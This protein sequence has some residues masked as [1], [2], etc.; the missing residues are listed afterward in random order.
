[1]NEVGGREM[2]RNGKG[3]KREAGEERRGKKSLQE[4]ERETGTKET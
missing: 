3:R 2:R 1:M 4:I